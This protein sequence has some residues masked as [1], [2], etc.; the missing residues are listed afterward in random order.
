MLMGL[1]SDLVNGDTVTVTLTFDGADPL[2]FDAVIENDR[3]AG[4][5]AEVEGG[6]GHGNTGHDAAAPD[7]TGMTDPDAVT[8]VMM[9]QFDTPENP[10]T[11]DPISVQ[12]DVAI[13]GWAQGDKGGRAF[14]RNGDMGWSIEVCAGALCKQTYSGSRKEL[15]TL[16][17]ECAG[18]PLPDWTQPNYPGYPLVVEGRRRTVVL[19]LSYLILPL[20]L[21]T[22]GLW[23]TRRRR[24][25]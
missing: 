6:H 1:T 23:V 21:S 7:T 9:A 11:V 16:L 20:A 12:G 13:A 8:A 18:Q 5:G 10:L 4:A 3:P 2:T 19:W 17:F 15:V 24:R 22:T 14:L 25:K